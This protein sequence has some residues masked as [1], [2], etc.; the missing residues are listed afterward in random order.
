MKRYAIE[1]VR[2]IAALFIVGCHLNLTPRTP[3]GYFMTH[4]C[5]MFV[6][7]F[8][9]IS[10]FLLAMSLEKGMGNQGVSVAAMIKRK[11]ARLLPIYFTWTA[12]YVV[13]G[14]VFDFV[15]DGAIGSKFYSKSNWM[16]F[17]FCGGASCHLWYIA[18]LFYISVLYIVCWRSFSFVRK[19]LFWLVASVLLLIVAVNWHSFWGYYFV[20]LAAF[21]ALGAFVNLYQHRLRS[22]SPWWAMLWFIAVVLLHPFSPVHA[23]YGDFL[24]SFVLFVLIT[25]PLVEGACMRFYTNRSVVRYMS[26]ASLGVF[27][28]HPI[29]CA[30]VGTFLRRVFPSPYGISCIAIDWVIC[31]V[32]A[33]VFFKVI[34]LTRFGSLVK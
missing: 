9:A 34:R 21:M 23:V 3:L 10:G 15:F 2:G 20:R 13:F 17:I 6:G 7:V 16:S 8:G 19:P 30:G 22:C 14:V 12:V 1:I 4:Y 11:M 24:V 32:L 25:N 33:L 27:L 28:V 18:A 5:D 26:E 31:Y 29:F